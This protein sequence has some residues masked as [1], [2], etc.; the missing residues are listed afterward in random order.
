[1]AMK[2]ISVYRSFIGHVAQHGVGRRNNSPKD[3]GPHRDTKTLFTRLPDDLCAPLL[4]DCVQ[5]YPDI[6]NY[7]GLQTSWATGEQMKAYKCLEAYNFFISGWVN[8]LLT[9]QLKDELQMAFY[10]HTPEGVLSSGA[11]F[12]ARDILK[13]RYGDSTTNT[14]QANPSLDN[15]SQD[16]T[17]GYT[18]DYTGGYAQDY[19]GG[20][21]QDYT[22]GY[23]Q[24][25]SGGY[26]QDN[27]GGYSQD[28][29]GGYTQDYTAD[30]YYGDPISG[31]EYNNN[32]S[33]YD[34]YSRPDP[35]FQYNAETGGQ[36]TF[37]NYD[38]QAN[39]STYLDNY[40]EYDFATEGNTYNSYVRQ[41]DSLRQEEEDFTGETET[42]GAYP[43]Y[44]NYGASRPQA[45]HRESPSSPPIQTE[46]N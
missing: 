29:N 20:Y 41:N 44:D 14:V 10:I 6:V 23:A 13:S 12:Q 36:D 38:S 46:V 2:E 21:A 7:L 35:S 1:M 34:A 16:Y 32:Y 33:T 42:K 26:T 28:Y 4:Y 5:K 25:Y 37:G 3:G 24:D 43:T 31:T 27:T 8:T 30:N 17:G 11:E 19:T 22:G 18:Q 45:D 9:K 39:N 15:Y 40:P